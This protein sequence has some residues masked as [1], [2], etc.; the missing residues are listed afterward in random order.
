MAR[1]VL[2]HCD[3]IADH[4][5]EHAGELNVIDPQL[6]RPHDLLKPPKETA[7]TTV[8]SP[9]PCNGSPPISS[10]PPTAPAGA[11]SKA[12]ATE[13]SSDL[14]AFTHR[15]FTDEIS[16]MRAPG[17]AGPLYGVSANGNHR[18][19]TARI[20]NL[21]WLAATV[22]VE[23]TP[24]SWGIPNLLASDNTDE[25]RRRLPRPQRA[26]KRQLLITGFIRRGI[27][28]G[29]LTGDRDW[30]I[31]RCRHLPAAWLLRAPQYATHVNAIYE[32]CY[33]GALAQLGIPLAIGTD[34]AAWCYRNLSPGMNCFWGST[35]VLTK[36]GTNA[37][38]HFRFD[39]WG[40]GCCG[41]CDIRVAWLGNHDDTARRR[42][43][44]MRPH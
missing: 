37:K 26:R 39:G 41:C 20:L 8:A 34:P 31:L 7:T 1:D 3:D 28:D 17:W 10:C 29:D 38:S 42:G 32:R 19:H 27:I 25:E 13:L 43:G 15:L 11:T 16:L 44:S 4:L 2:A 14:E 6:Q 9:K 33:P 40:R 21:P 36:R 35:L 12:T 30:P 18:V 5:A 24:P 22:L 23:P